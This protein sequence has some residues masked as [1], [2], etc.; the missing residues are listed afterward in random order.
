MYINE[1]IKQLSEL[2]STKSME[3]NSGK[4]CLSDIGHLGEALDLWGILSFHGRDRV[5]FNATSSSQ[6]PQVPSD[7]RDNQAS[8][9]GIK[10]VVNTIWYITL[11]GF[12]ILGNNP[13]EE[14]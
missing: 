9:A 4:V 8:L 6:E 12:L 2:S 7:F 1:N 10:A 13:P 5:Q 14:W 3:T 11:H